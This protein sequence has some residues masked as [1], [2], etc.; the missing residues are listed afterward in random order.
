MLRLVPTPPARAAGLLNRMRCRKVQPPR[1][2][3]RSPNSTFCLP[4][5]RAAPLSNGNRTAPW[6]PLQPTPLHARTSAAHSSRRVSAEKVAANHAKVAARRDPSSLGSRVRLVKA[7]V[8]P[9]TPVASRVRVVVANLES[10]APTSHAN[11]G[12][13]PVSHVPSSRVSPAV[14]NGNSSHAPINPIKLQPSVP[15]P[16]RSRAAS[17]AG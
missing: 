5:T 6:A 8:N 7:V 4:R 16:R 3:L 17:S 1:K 15:S 14:T 13:T 12:V 2:A 9:G 11:P 10:R